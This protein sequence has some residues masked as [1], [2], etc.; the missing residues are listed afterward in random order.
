MVIPQKNCG[1]KENKKENE[2]DKD[3]A[4]DLPLI[5][6]LSNRKEKESS[7]F[8]SK[9]ANIQWNNGCDKIYKIYAMRKEKENENE[10]DKENEKEKVAQKEKDKEK[11]KDKAKE[12]ES[13][14]F[15]HSSEKSREGHEDVFFGCQ[16]PQIYS[17]LFN[18]Y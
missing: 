5:L 14:I 16:C 1:N 12:K 17:A 3:K 2:K 7:L 13:L 6:Y 15:P 11:E 8:Y 18:A 4:K 9:I 10:R